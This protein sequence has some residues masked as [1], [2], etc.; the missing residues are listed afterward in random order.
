M[1][2]PNNCRGISISSILLKVLCTLLNNRIQSY[3]TKSDLINKNQI[4]FKSNYRTSGH[5]LTLKSVLKKYVTIGEKKQFSCFI[6]FSNALNSIWHRGIFHKFANIGFIGKSLDL[7]KNIYK[8][9][10]CAVKVKG[11]YN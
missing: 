7:I 4:G 11:S 6:D 1:Q 8:N 3:C 5:L 2:D 10:R 9:T